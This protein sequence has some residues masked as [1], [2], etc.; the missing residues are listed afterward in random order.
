MRATGGTSAPE[1][2]SPISAVQ[3]SE[4]SEVVTEDEAQEIFLSLDRLRIEAYSDPAS[5]DLDEFL[6][7]DSPLRRLG[8]KEFAQL[9][10]QKIHVSQTTRRNELTFERV[11]HDSL[12]L[13]QK[14]E[15]RL[16]FLTSEGDEVG[17]YDGWEARSV[18]WTLR[19]YP[20]GWRIY[21]SKL[22]EAEKI[23]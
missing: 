2:H 19:L 4:S 1:D 21:N 5:A 9:R 6:A 20:E 14:M 13:E 23:E 18:R 17:S 8:K 11:E 7:I 3:Q 16:R 12:V 10:R 22:L 15:R